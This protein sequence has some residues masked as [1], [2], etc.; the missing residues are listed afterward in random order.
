[1]VTRQGSQID[2][3][4]GED[5]AACYNWPYEEDWFKLTL[6]LAENAEVTR[7]LKQIEDDGPSWAEGRA[8][9]IGGHPRFWQRDVREQSNLQNID[10]FLLHLSADDKDIRLGDSGALNLMISAKA[11]EARNVNAAYCTWD[12]A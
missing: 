2:F 3:V 10:R 5:R 7:L 12:C 11:L 6:R 1:M 9:W 4:A 8:G